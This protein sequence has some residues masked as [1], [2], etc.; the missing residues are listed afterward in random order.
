MSGAGSG[1]WFPTTVRPVCWAA[2]EA[3]VQISSTRSVSRTESSAS[4]TIAVFTFAATRQPTVRLEGAPNMRHR[5]VIL[6]EVGTYL[7]SVPHSAF[8]RSS[9]VD[10]RR[11]RYGPHGG[12]IGPGGEYLPS[13]GNTTDIH[14]QSEI[15]AKPRPPRCADGQHSPDRVGAHQPPSSEVACSILLPMPDR[16]R[17]EVSTR[18]R[19]SSRCPSR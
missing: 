11:A 15:D 5:Y 12:G 19:P 1:S 8:G 14:A 2:H 16:G 3:R 18:R 4:R 9:A 6:D 17:I 10:L 7:G 13:S